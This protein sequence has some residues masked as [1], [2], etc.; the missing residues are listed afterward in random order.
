VRC[1]AQGPTVILIESPGEFIQT[2]AVAHDAEAIEETA[3]P[4]VGDPP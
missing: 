1:E 3:L 4:G 2:V